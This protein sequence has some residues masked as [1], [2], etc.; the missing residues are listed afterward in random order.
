M[1]YLTNGRK[2]GEL[3]IYFLNILFNHKIQVYSTKLYILYSY[4]ILLFLYKLAA[5]LFAA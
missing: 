4:S 1:L 2:F 5:S 3:L